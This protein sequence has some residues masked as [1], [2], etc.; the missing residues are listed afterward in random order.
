MGKMK[1]LNIQCFVKKNFESIFSGANDPK[2]LYVSKIV[3]D[4]SVYPRIMHA[5][6]DHIEVILVT[7]GSSEYLIHNT[8]YNVKAGDVL[9]YNSRVVHDEVS[10][11]ENKIGSYCVGIGGLH[12]P[13]LRDN[14]LIPDDAGFVF[15][16]GEYFD[17]L[18]TLMDI[19]FDNLSAEKPYAEEYCHSLMHAFL[20]RVLT[21]TG[22]KSLL[23]SGSKKID[24]PN[25][26]GQRI[27]EYIDEHYM[28]AIT[29]QSIGDALYISP[30]YL[31]HVFKEMS[32][33]SPM[34][35]LLRRRI[36]EAQTL[37]TTT[38]H[39]ILRISEMVGYETQNYF[40]LQFTKYVGMSPNQFRQNYIVRQTEEQEKGNTKRNT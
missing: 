34:Q 25:V 27:K 40:S 38:N 35:Y 19:M 11:S 30:Y 10:G 36:G 13:G 23:E 7:S 21:V 24:D 4:K 39:S 2:L 20:I 8:K 22:D 33:Y 26:L 15:S 3:P 18:R 16:A 37:L 12:M 6:E 29:L 17:E 9:I 1:P 32:G 31:S 5:H 28:E 14:A